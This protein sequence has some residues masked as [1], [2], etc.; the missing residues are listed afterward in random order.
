MA[1]SS[2]VQALLLGLVKRGRFV[3]LVSAG[4]P[5]APVWADSI[6]HDGHP[7]ARASVPRQ[8]AA[9]DGWCTLS[10]YVVFLYTKKSKY[11]QPG[12]TELRRTNRSRQTPSRKESNQLPAERSSQITPGS[13]KKSE[14]LQTF[15]A[16]IYGRAGETRRGKFPVLG[17]RKFLHSLRSDVRAVLTQP[18]LI[19]P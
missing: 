8:E 9:G 15:S 10:F 14:K 12:V 5:P 16:S 18:Y 3:E 11:A 1:E 17:Q 7:P 2:S 4:T 6:A 19:T 13:P